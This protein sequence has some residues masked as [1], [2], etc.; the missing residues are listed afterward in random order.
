MAEVRYEFRATGATDVLN[1]FRGVTRAAEQSAR[2][3]DK[4][5][6]RAGT[7]TSRKSSDAAYRDAEKAAARHERELAKEVRATERAEAR[8]LAV[9]MRAETQAQ[10]HAEKLAE[11]DRARRA[12]TLST[13]GADAL[14]G[15]AGGVLA[16][17]AGATGIAISAAR[18]SMKLDE[19]TRRIAINSRQAGQAGIDPG[20]LKS[21]V[22]AAALATPG[23]KSLDLA[24]AIGAFVTKTG[25]V[26]VA[27]SMAG[28]F[29]TTASATGSDVRDI[30]Q[31]AADLFEKFDI[32]SVNEMQEALA[33]LTFQGKEGAFELKDAASQFGKLSAAASRF[34]LDKGA[35]G[36]RVLG[37]LTQIAR[38][39]TGSPEQAASA[40]E[41][42]MRQLVSKSDVLEK[43]GASPF[44]KGS[45]S[46]T[47]PIEDVLVDT[48]AKS[49]GEL[50]KLQ[51]IFGEEGIR[52]ISPLISTFNQAAN[53]AGG[54][55]TDAGQ[56][57]GI[58]A[59][60]A[61]LD[62]AINATA[63][64]TEVQKDAAAAQKM[65]TSQLTAAWERVVQQAGD[66]LAPALADLVTKLGKSNAL[67]AFV[68][69]IEVAAETLAG[70][71]ELLVSLGLVQQKKATPQ[72][73]YDQAVA[74]LDAFE[75]KVAGREL[76]EGEQQQYDQLRAAVDAADVARFVSGKDL[77]SAMSSEQF[78]DEWKRLQGED[79][80]KAQA[81]GLEA[82]ARA[83]IAAPFVGETAE[84]EQF[85]R[86]YMASRQGL[87]QERSEFAEKSG[88]DTSAL[89]AE[90]Q[91]IAKL[92]EAASKAAGALNKIE[93]GNRP[94][95]VAGQ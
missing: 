70:L 59:L 57:A 65:T 78:A 48:I 93:A 23:I 54:P 20:Q 81:V 42:T 50:P 44:V 80:M 28:T 26:D 75:E 68:L 40:I 49:K 77:T 89:D 45:K 71:S 17:A 39:S 58:A 47:R 27:R 29:A 6:R 53:A 37:G 3:V 90:Q 24:E 9:R 52:G 19:V 60:K 13:L 11:S 34:G 64:W 1:A 66:K 14:K 73:A 12:R 32:K 21:E 62:K 74:N 4:V 87:A 30:S 10:K 85:R 5:H 36:V 94:S 82:D 22:Q 33:A 79:A 25:R 18:D 2:A 16:G 46:K 56:A 35:R 43:M 41:A 55:R 88:V 38:S 8:K 67:D 92:A 84:A 72:A 69:A 63:S 83:G 95:I 91:A 76:T 86:D 7:A 15:A 31:A 51:E 61:Q